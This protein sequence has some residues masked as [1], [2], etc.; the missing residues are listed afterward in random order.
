VPVIKCLAG[1]RKHRIP[2]D[3]LRDNS[4]GVGSSDLGG[5]GLA[6]LWKVTRTTQT[7]KIWN[8]ERDAAVRQLLLPH[9]GPDWGHVTIKMRG[10]PSFIAQVI[11]NG[12]DS[13]AGAAHA[14]EVGF[15][16]EGNCLTG[17][18]EPERLA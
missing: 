6:S 9:H 4:V 14:A 5:A 1:E 13:V 8:L 3:N 11:L 15:A 17:I 16:K 18:G 2:E 12:H 10:H 7:W